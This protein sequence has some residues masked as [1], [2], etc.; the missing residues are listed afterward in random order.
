M[1]FTL[2]NTLSGGGAL[3]YQTARNLPHVFFGELEAGK[4]FPAE[5][6][7]G[8]LWHVK[9]GPSS[10]RVS[11][12]AEAHFS[13]SVSIDNGTQYR[14]GGVQELTEAGRMAL[15]GEGFEEDLQEETMPAVDPRG[16]WAVFELDKAFDCSAQ[17]SDGCSLKY[18][19]KFF[20][21]LQEGQ[22]MRVNTFV[23]HKWSV[24]V[25]GE[26]VWRGIIDHAPDHQNFHIVK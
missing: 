3:F 13:T 18:D 6:F 21:P 22:P 7:V 20:S 14:A 17:P 9:V 23:G 16:R 12:D 2:D 19:G 24:D 5:S 10:S 15:A 11:P 1:I 25:A 8:H 26:E 4:P